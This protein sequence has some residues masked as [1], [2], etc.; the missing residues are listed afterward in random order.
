MPLFFSPKKYVPLHCSCF[1]LLRKKI[2]S[3]IIFSVKNQPQHVPTVDLCSSGSLLSIWIL[4]KGSR[5][6]D[7]QQAGLTLQLCFETCRTQSVT[8]AAPLQ[9]Q[10][11]LDRVEGFVG[12]RDL[13]PTS[14]SSSFPHIHFSSLHFLFLIVLFFFFFSNDVSLYC[15]WQHDC[16]FWKRLKSHSVWSGAFEPLLRTSVAG[17]VASLP[18]G[19]FLEGVD[20]KTLTFWVV[21]AETSGGENFTGVCWDSTPSA[22]HD[23]LQL[24]PVTPSEGQRVY[25]WWL[26]NNYHIWS[27]RG[28][29]FGLQLRSKPAGPS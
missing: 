21:V 20:W 23:M 14:E 15:V 16:H 7:D 26:Y 18:V 27:L 29:S 17:G 6:N 9:S 11:S 8:A 3:P 10:L 24:T 25:K 22:P 13:R 28:F 4:Y 5:T 1:G 2:L 19:N 12:L